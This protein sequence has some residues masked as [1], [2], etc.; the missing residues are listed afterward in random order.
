MIR[1]RLLD[2]VEDFIARGAP[3]EDRFERLALDVFRYQA[4]HNAAYRRLLESRCI[5][6]GDVLGW[7]EIPAVSSVAFKHLRLACGPTMMTFRTSGTTRGAA[8]RGEHHLGD[9]RLYRA[10]L[11]RHFRECVLPDRETIRF[12][13]LTPAPE[14]APDSSLG[15]MMEDLHRTCGAPGSAYFLTP[16]GV[17]IDPLIRELAR[18]EHD[19]EAICLCGVAFAFVHLLDAMRERGARFRLPE[20]SRLMD[21]GGFKGR[22]RS[23][24]RADLVHEYRERFGLPP[25]AVVNEYG[26]T[27]LGSQFYDH[28]LHGGDPEVKH[29][30]HWVRTLVIDP[31]GGQVLEDGCEG[32][33]VHFDLANADSVLAVETED[34]G[35]VR[36]G[37]FVLSGRAA[38]A[39]PRG[40]SLVVP[41]PPRQ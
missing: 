12:L 5:A 9:V 24:E 33:L 23:V 8:G 3:D 20:G 14:W 4:T 19:G 1:A 2:D 39:E 28:S 29:G 32:L 26:M 30:P 25:S 7:R 21:T 6:P 13:S 17:A 11:R 38:G 35:V 10:A 18:A 16:E 22:S 36:G 40:C 37:G 31:G 27:E 41:D 15:F 34:L